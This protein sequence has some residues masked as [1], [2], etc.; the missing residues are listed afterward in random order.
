MKFNMGEKIKTIFDIGNTA[1]INKIQTTFSTFH[2]KL[3]KCFLHESR[4]GYRNLY[5]CQTITS[6]I[7]LSRS[8]M[9]LLFVYIYM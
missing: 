2:I 9:N 5:F 1:K 7:E 3:L 4:S 6:L 8:P